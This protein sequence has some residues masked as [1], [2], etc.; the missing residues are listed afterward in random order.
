[1]SDIRNQR[2]SYSLATKLKLSAKDEQ[3]VKIRECQRR[4]RKEE[5]YSSPSLIKSRNTLSQNKPYTNL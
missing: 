1:M 4:Q 5:L 3:L 2:T